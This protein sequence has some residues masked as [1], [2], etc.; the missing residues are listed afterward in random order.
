M[1]KDVKRRLLIVGGVIAGGAIAYYLWQQYQERQLL[2]IGGGGSGGG[3]G[4]GMLPPKFGSNPVT[5]PN[6]T[7]VAAYQNARNQL[8]AYAAY[9]QTNPPKTQSELAAAQAKMETLKQQ[10]RVAAAAIGVNSGI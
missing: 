5:G 7:L 10:V 6:P 9:I 4:G 1:R 8:N 2:E 3:G